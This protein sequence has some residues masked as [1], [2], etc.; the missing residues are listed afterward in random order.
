MS[1]EET[2]SYTINKLIDIL[3]IPEDRL[4]AFLPE[5]KNWAIMTKATLDLLSVI[6]EATG[7][8]L[9]AK[10]TGMTWVDDGDEKITIKLEQETT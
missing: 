7:E 8:E 6:A 3:T 10:E 1:E 5:L 9:P 4:D 2:K